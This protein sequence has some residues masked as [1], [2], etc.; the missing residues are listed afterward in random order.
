MEFVKDLDYEKVI[1]FLNREF[2][3]SSERK[4][5]SKADLNGIL[6]L[7]QS[8]RERE[9]IRYAV[10]KASGITP[11]QAQKHFGF[12]NMS[13][14]ASEVEKCIAEAQEIRAAIDDLA[15]SQDKALLAT[16]G[17]VD[18]DD[19][20]TSETDS[21]DEF[22]HDNDAQASEVEKCIAEAQEIRAAIDDLADSQDKAL[23]AT[24]GIVDE[25]D[26]STSETDSSDEFS[27]DNDAQD[28]NISNSFLIETLKRCEYNWFEFVERIE[29]VIEGPTDVSKGLDK[30]FH[31]IPDLG[32][33]ETEIEKNIPLTQCFLGRRE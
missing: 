4:M 2:A 11:N 15:D 12:D 10:Y 20:S 8:D 25:D 6:K 14:R 7:A 32:F 23:L 19:S 17:I 18:E 27:H 1:G 9:T 26:S 33:S 16:Y 22:S 28:L 31:R 29:A 3:K 24:Y 21:S 5:L 13:S 30:F